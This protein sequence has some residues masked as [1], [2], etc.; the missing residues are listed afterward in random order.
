VHAPA[1]LN[2]GQ[3]IEITTATDFL[4]ESQ[5]IDHPIMLAQFFVGIQ[6]V[7]TDPT[8]AMDKTNVGDPSLVLAIPTQQYRD[9]YTFTTPDTIARDFITVVRPA[10]ATVALDATPMNVT[11]API[12]STGWEV[13]RM[14]ITDGTHKLTANQPVGL[15]VYGFDWSVSYGYPGGLDLKSLVVINPGG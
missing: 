2:A 15:S 9:A 7:V 1:T 11:W 4:V 3:F 5:D 8:Q 14:E 6:T 13:G 12:G 10:G